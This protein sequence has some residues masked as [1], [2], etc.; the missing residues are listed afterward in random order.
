MANNYN[1]IDALYNQYVELRYTGE[2]AERSFMISI[3][4][5]QKRLLELVPNKSME[6]ATFLNMTQ[7]DSICSKLEV[8]HAEARMAEVH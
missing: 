1:P 8:A 2:S 4:T 7:S 5:V 6:L 3:M